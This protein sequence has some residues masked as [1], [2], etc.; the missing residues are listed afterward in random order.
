MH[1]LT[2]THPDDTVSYETFENE[3]E[4]FLHLESIGVTY[5]SEIGVTS[6]ASGYVYEYGEVGK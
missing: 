3:R 6:L 2:V 5:Y 1:S 4:I